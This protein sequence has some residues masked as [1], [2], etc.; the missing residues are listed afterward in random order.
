M[1]LTNIAFQTFQSQITILTAT[2]N[3]I[4]LLEDL[5]RS[6]CKQTNLNFI[7]FVID[8]G[9]IDGTVD[10]LKEWQ[11]EELIKISYI[12]TENQGKNRA[13]N[14]AMNYITTNYVAIIDSDDILLSDAIAFMNEKAILFLADNSAGFAGLRTE[15]NDKFFKDQVHD[16]FI[17]NYERKKYGLEKDACEVY[18]TS[19][20]KLFPFRVWDGETFSPEEIV[21]NEIGYQGY[22]LHWFRY[23]LCL[24][25]Y[26]P[27]GLTKSSNNL[28]KKNPMGYAMLYNHRLIYSSSLKNKI[29]NS[30]FV[31]AYSL[32]GKNPL[33]I[34]SFKCLMSKL[35]AFPIG[36]AIYFRRIWQYK[37]NKF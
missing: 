3:R 23:D 12:R 14:L 35:F 15:T 19:I 1:D 25:R 13:I 21:W 9:S 26:Q 7:W 36:L 8:D 29:Y 10:K 32:L 2:Y 30:A 28:I 4:T 27:D 17:P 34:F 24:V 6:L 16:T 31:V 22:K 18:K 11:C 33:Y 5:Y 37:N 20:L